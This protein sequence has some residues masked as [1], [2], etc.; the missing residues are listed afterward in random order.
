M[1]SNVIFPDR[2][3]EERGTELLRL[4]ACADLLMGL[5]VLAVILVLLVQPI[6]TSGG[7][8]ESAMVP[9]KVACNS[10]EDCTLDAARLCAGRGGKAN[11]S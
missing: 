4:L 10:A 1:Q 9:H 5:L 3:S 2:L 7:G 8:T 6:S 11:R